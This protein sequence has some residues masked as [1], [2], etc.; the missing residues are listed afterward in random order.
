MSLLAIGNRSVLD[1]FCRRCDQ[2]I[3]QN[4]LCWSSV[5]RHIATPLSRQLV[6]A[7][8]RSAGERV[9]DLLGWREAELARRGDLDRL[10]GGGI[11]SLACRAVL[12]LEL[13]ETGKTDFLP[14]LRR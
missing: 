1:L 2:P 10:A 8:A 6:R 3:R 5:R 12:D 13:A 11:A 9:L 14:L 7:V 4:W